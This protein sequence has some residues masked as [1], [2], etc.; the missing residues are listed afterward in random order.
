M[1]CIAVRP[2]FPNTFFCFSSLLLSSLARR[3]FLPSAIFWTSRGHRCRPFCFS[4]PVRAVIFCPA[5]NTLNNYSKLPMGFY[6]STYYLSF[7]SLCGVPAGAVDLVII[8][9]VFYCVRT[10]GL[11]RLCSCLHVGGC[12]YCE[13]SINNNNRTAS[14]RYFVFHAIT[15]WSALADDKYS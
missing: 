12:R 15:R 7:V 4:P 3:R 11:K 14:R 8:G 9:G 6:Y 1:C 5:I 13:R 10:H 2:R